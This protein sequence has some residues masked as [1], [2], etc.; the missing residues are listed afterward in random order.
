VKPIAAR[1]TPIVFGV[2]ATVAAAV[3]VAADTPAASTP[4]AERVI[5]IAEV[6]T[7]ADAAFDTADKDESG[8]LSKEEFATMPGRGMD[9]RGHMGRGAMAQGPRPYGAGPDGGPNQGKG[10][11][12]MGP[13]SA[14][15]RA[16]MHKALFAALDADGNGQ[17][18]AE[19]FD[20]QP[21]AMAE[22]RRE[23]A[24]TRLDRNG[25]GVLSRDELPSPVA[26][27]ERAD[28]DGDGRVTPDEMRAQRRGGW[29]RKSE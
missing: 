11:G 6:K 14:E 9:E 3:A 16:T 22:L 27:L 10:M 13:P 15:D 17:L 7:R 28:A 29:S 26:R 2:A 12:G 24:F 19:E 4:K 23:R 8:T 20:R 21:E 25:D 5:D 1:L 18:S